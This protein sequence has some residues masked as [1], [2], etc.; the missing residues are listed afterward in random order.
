MDE[1]PAKGKD[2]KRPDATVL[3]KA[4]PASKESK[5]VKPGRSRARS[6]WGKKKDK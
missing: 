3:S 5:D 2:T 1:S 6:I 4:E